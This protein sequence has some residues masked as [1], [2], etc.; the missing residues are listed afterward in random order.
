MPDT[1]SADALRTET[2][3]CV[4]VCRQEEGIFVT[5]KEIAQGK[6]LNPHA[7]ESYLRFSYLAGDEGFSGE[8][9]T[10][11]TVRFA[12]AP[13]RTEGEYLRELE[14]ILDA[15]FEEERKHADAA[16]LSSGVDSSLIA[17][18][19]R[20]KKTFSVAYEEKAFDESAPALATAKKLGS[21]HHVVKIGPAD[22]FGAVTDAMAARGNPTGDASYVALFLAAGEAACHTGAVCSGEGPDEMFCGYP[23]YSR[24]FDDP[25][26]DFWLKTNTIMEIGPVDFPELS[27]YR[28]DG[29]LKM[30]AFDL[31]RWL[32]GN[33]LP[34]VHAAAKGTGI[35]IR[36]PYMRRELM[37]FALALPVRYKADRT[38]GKILFR[39][40]ARRWTGAEI[41]QREKRGFPVPVRRWMRLEPWKTQITDALT[42]ET[43]RRV[44]DFVDREGILR[45]FYAGADETL[46]KQIWEMFVLIRWYDAVKGTA[47]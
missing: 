38:M 30:N 12:F 6:P 18:G 2:A 42:G 16:F 39:K 5:K 11:P 37:D 29:F 40:A 4:C 10:Y 21:E 15:I 27:A 45:A 20:A 19:I 23:C 1:E 3:E 7:L 32:Y 35:D 33:I 26:E 46:W 8:K 36:T 13:E 14:G 31:S 17:C 9:L 25:G 24:Y 47:S 28:G 34:N 43:A 41:A 44:L 22:F